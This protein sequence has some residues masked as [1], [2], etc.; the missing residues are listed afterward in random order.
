[1]IHLI[2]NYLLESSLCLILFLVAYRI[3]LANMTHFSWMRYYLLA[4]MALSVI[5]PFM[6]IPVEWSA[7][8]IPA[9]S[10]PNTVLMQPEQAATTTIVNNHPTLTQVDSGTS[11]LTVVL[12]IAFIAYMIGAIYKTYLFARSLK[13]IHELI[14]KSAKVKEENYWVVS[15]K[16]EMPAFSFFNYV[17]MNS[18]YKNLSP[19]ELQVIK[20]HE[21]MHV[22][23]RHTLDILVVEL[24]A[25]LFWFNPIVSYLRK[26]LKEIHEYMVDER[27]AGHGEHKKAYA[28]L[29]LNLASDTKVFDLAASFAGE[30]VKRRILMIAKPR[31]SV[32]YKLMC[33]MIIPLSAILSLSFASLKEPELDPKNQHE[34]AAIRPDLQKYC[35]V[36]FP[37]KEDAHVLKPMEIR[38]KDNKLFSFM[39]AEPGSAGVTVELQF[40]AGNISPLT[41]DHAGSTFSF[42]DKSARSITFNLDGEKEVT[43]CALVKMVTKGHADYLVL[44]G[45]YSKRTKLEK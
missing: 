42:T 33:F 24:V 9:D 40:E 1:M 19:R 14:K 16:S 37:S 2:F 11:I 10:L 7:R 8:L 43:G 36:Y 12:F 41:D 21:L 13:R 18:T 44:E 3:L 17:F 25:I 23:C 5:L 4:S 31:T 35:G 39:E 28:Q 32:K 38:L 26:S 45:R 20:E 30:H 34:N 15:L 22:K 27:I 29:L 6:I